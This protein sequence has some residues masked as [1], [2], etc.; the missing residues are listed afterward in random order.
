[1]INYKCN[2]ISAHPIFTA[3]CLRR[4]KCLH[5][6]L[7]TQKLSDVGYEDRIK[8]A[9]NLAIFSTYESLGDVGSLEKVVETLL[10]ESKIG[11][12]IVNA[13]DESTGLTPFMNC[14]T[15]IM[16]KKFG[17]V[18]HSAV[19]NILTMLI[20]A[21][22]SMSQSRMLVPPLVYACEAKLDH[23]VISLMLERGANPN[24]YAGNCGQTCLN[25]AI[26]NGQT[27]TV[28]ILLDHGVDV[29]VMGPNGKKPFTLAYEQKNKTLTKTI[30]EQATF[31]FDE[32]DFVNI[33]VPV[34]LHKVSPE[35]KYYSYFERKFRCEEHKMVKEPGLD[36]LDILFQ[37]AMEGDI[38][39]LKENLD[40]C[41]NHDLNTQNKSGMTLLHI[42]AMN[43]DVDMVELLLKSGA[44]VEVK[45]SSGKNG[46]LHAA[47]MSNS[48]EI[49]DLLVSYGGNVN[50]KGT[51]GRTALFE[52]AQ[53][54]RI[55]NVEYLCCAGA[56]ANIGEERNGTTPIHLVAQENN[57]NILEILLK[58]STTDVN[59]RNIFGAGPLHYA[60]KHDAVKAA[61][62]LI[63]KGALINIECGIK[64]NTPL[65][66]ASACNSTTVAQV[67]VEKGANV[68]K[69][70]K[71][72]E[73]PLFL[74][75]MS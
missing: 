14:I 13:I 44:K 32:T 25:T 4:P 31:R 45:D 3:V 70:N 47:K 23:T 38:A 9:L 15:F 29:N 7:R 50:I 36:F 69:A 64:C 21:G 12:K 52:A 62:L 19:T 59:R 20:K 46:F 60:A 34:V 35:D 11:Q 26:I 53:A 28:M 66:V 8:K 22:A 10:L 61:L 16:S 68:S 73:T 49:L 30:F 41:G 43:N 37:L 55:E 39:K 5:L 72:Q 58:T 56:D 18:T 67:L 33:N 74:A 2:A 40:K 71:H 6:L 65:H 48:L 54:N 75:A 51:R 24:G 57:I 42:A 1:M 63:S 17:A 27:R